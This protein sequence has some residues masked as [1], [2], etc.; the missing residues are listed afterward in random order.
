MPGGEDSAYLA[1]RKLL[2]DNGYDVT[3]Y[4][5]SNEELQGK[6]GFYSAALIAWN[7]QAAGDV[8]ELIQKHRPQVMHCHNTFGVMSPAVYG[9][10]RAQGVP[11]VQ[12]LHNFRSFCANALLFRDGQ[13]CEQCVGK[14]IPL[15]A[16]K[17]ACYRDSRTATAA[18]TG[19]QVLHRLLKTGERCISR[20]I[21]LT[22]FARDKF[23][24]GGL[25]ESR[26]RVIP[27]FADRVEGAGTAKA[28]HVLFM[29]RLSS[30][31]GVSV[32][33]DAWKSISD[34]PL[35]VAGKGPLEAEVRDAEGQMAAVN[36]VGWK[37]REEIRDLIARARFVM[38][39]SLCYE[40]FP[41]TLVEAFSQGVPVIA[42]AHG[43]PG[44]VLREG[45]TGLL[46]PPGDVG[47][48]ADAVERGWKMNDEEYAAMQN[49]CRYDF[50]TYYSPEAHLKALTNVYAELQ[51]GESVRQRGS[52]T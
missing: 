35:V 15:P 11:V 51:N 49:H 34:I 37:T 25:P 2:E 6:S 1:H 14:T 10:A 22:D 31:K 40:G 21:A 44:R 9:A 26:I 33:L 32:L 17:Y 30:E 13:V 38:V 42:F 43:G 3:C 23:V 5:R 20:Y 36:Y 8:A 47:A 41:V 19:S 24:E 18:L 16:M 4:E 28:E 46:V 27:N 50:Q 29:G 39:P 52:A 45:E 48:L 7:R 12:T